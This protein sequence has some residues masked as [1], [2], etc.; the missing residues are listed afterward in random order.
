MTKR[1]IL[2]RHAKSG[3]D[4][5]LLQDI[6]R[7]LNERGRKS[8]TALGGW[9]KKHNYVPDTVL[10]SSATRTRETFEGLDVTAPTTFKR[11]LYL[12]PAGVML[13]WLRQS[14]G[15]TLLL[16]GHNPGIAELAE[17]VLDALPD[18]T[19]F[20]FYPTGATLICDF[21]IT[22]W[23]DASSASARLVDFIVP[24]DLID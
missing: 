5:P 12:A 15:D 11:E 7:P 22:N 2:M 18:H 8:A 17:T 1:L 9:L 14:G 16:I 20:P 10:S 24:R 21:P 13:E 6:E 4:D 19:R 23:A 3:W